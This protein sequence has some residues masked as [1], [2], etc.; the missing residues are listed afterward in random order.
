[1]F[2]IAQLVGKM[3]HHGLGCISHPFQ[4][5]VAGRKILLV[6]K[7]NH[8][9]AGHSQWHTSLHH[10]PLMTHWPVQQGLKTDPGQTATGLQ[11]HLLPS[12][13]V[14]QFKQHFVKI[15]LPHQRAQTITPVTTHFI[16]RVGI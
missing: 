12:P 9:A 14:F 5:A 8:M 13:R 3:V 6:N 1:M 2:E 7:Q 11:S 4:S 15:P 10:P 16:D